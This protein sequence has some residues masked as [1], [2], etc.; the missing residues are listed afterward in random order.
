M[1]IDRVD[2]A[3]KA[4]EP[5]WKTGD[6]CEIEGYDNC[7]TFGCDTPN[8]T[9]CVVFRSYDNSHTIVPKRWL[10][11]PLSEA[12][13]NREALINKLLAAFPDTEDGEDCRVYSRRVCECLV[14]AGLVHE[15]QQ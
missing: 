11:K 5:E 10:L 7:W 14:D 4:D 13:K 8:G 12:K 9:D 15:S 2:Q 3:K 6:K 1:D